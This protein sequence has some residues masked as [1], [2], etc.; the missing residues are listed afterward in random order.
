MENM[1]S[2]CFLFCIGKTEQ[3]P[4]Q[5]RQ[6]AAQCF[7]LVQGFHWVQKPW[8]QSLLL[9]FPQHFQ[10][11]L[12]VKVVLVSC[13]L[14][15]LSDKRDVLTFSGVFLL[16]Q[17]GQTGAKCTDSDWC[18]NE[19]NSHQEFHRSEWSLTEI[20]RDIPAETLKVYLFGNS[21][22]SIPDGAFSHLTQCIRLQLEKN[23]FASINKTNFSGMKSLKLLWL[24][25]NKIS[26]IESGSFASLKKLSELDLHENHLSTIKSGMFTGLNLLKQLNLNTNKISVVGEGSFDSLHSLKRINLGRNQ[27]T[28]LSADLFINVP[29]PLVLV[30]NNTDSDTNGFICRSL[31]WLRHEEQHG[32]VFWFHD[33]LPRCIDLTSWRL[34]LCGDQGIQTFFLITQ[35]KAVHLTP[36]QTLRVVN[37]ARYPQESLLIYYW[38]TTPKFIDS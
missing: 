14:D 13:A 15:F 21:I 23:L 16:H 25:E 30:L 22:T 37:L 2:H 4:E 12:E 35:E 33:A 26:K 27:L 3:L 7:I 31:C 34:I 32:T 1:T 5:L 9:L 8:V 17:C 38:L 19:Y 10:P 18:K 29:R 28:T 11:V 20:P 6:H 36:L 24:W